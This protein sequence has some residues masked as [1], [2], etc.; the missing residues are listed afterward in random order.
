MH[1]TL[2]MVGARPQARAGAASAAAPARRCCGRC[3]QLRRRRG[4]PAAAAWGR[5]RLRAGAAAGR[6]T[7]RSIARG[8]ALEHALL[9]P[10]PPGEPFPP[11]P[12]A[13]A[14]CSPCSS[15]GRGRAQTCGP[16]CAR[17]AWRGSRARL[18]GAGARAAGGLKGRGRLACV[19]A[20]NACQ[21]RL[22]L[23]SGTGQAAGRAPARKRAAGRLTG[24]GAE[25][26]DGLTAV[27][28]AAQQ[29][30]VAAGGRHQR[31]LVESHD[32]AASLQPME[33]GAPDARV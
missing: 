12:A 9:H 7:V 8:G 15:G 4:A 3:R 22:R 16:C 25:V 29:H 26:L 23:S 20:I 32:L 5:L 17:T 21:Q 27:L 6:G 13:P 11:A 30:A 19:Q 14:P 28:G 18:Q 33:R 10:R 2:G 1:P 24:R 31:Q